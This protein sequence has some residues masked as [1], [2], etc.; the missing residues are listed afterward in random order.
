M[1]KD[2]P[3]LFVRFRNGQLVPEDNITS[4]LI[5]LYPE[6][7]LFKLEHRTRKD[8]STEQNNL[9]WLCL[10]KICKATGLYPKAH[11]LHHELLIATGNY[12]L[13]V[14]LEGGTRK[15]PDSTKFHKMP[16]DEFTA[17]FAQAKLVLLEHGIDVQDVM[18]MEAA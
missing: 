2:T 3:E 12:R 6:N 10:S 11:V 8:R 17:Y 16:H 15:I 5:A 7:C 9:Y 18:E 14:S 1:A 4:Q 13:Q